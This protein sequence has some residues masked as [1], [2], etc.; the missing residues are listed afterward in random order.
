[1]PSLFRFLFTVG[2]LGG[3]TVGGLWAL[4]QFFEPTSKEVSQPVPGGLKVKR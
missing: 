1:M 3:I 2:L 4:Q